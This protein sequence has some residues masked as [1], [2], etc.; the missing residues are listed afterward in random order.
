VGKKQPLAATGAGGRRLRFRLPGKASV[1]GFRAGFGG[2][3]EN[4]YTD[5]ISVR[6]TESPDVE[7]ASDES[8]CV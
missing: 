4:M 7:E 3:A 5:G 2:A 6:A 8:D 1:H